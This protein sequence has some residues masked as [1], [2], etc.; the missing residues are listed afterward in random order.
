M[1]TFN[2]P[3]N[4]KQK[5]IEYEMKCIDCKACMKNCPMLDEFCTSPKEL[6]GR[7]GSADTQPLE[8][9]F[10]CSLC[11]YCARVCPKDINFST[12]FHPMREHIIASGSV[13]S[14]PLSKGLSV[15]ANHQK[16]SF[17]KAFSSS[18]P[19]A[20]KKAKTAFIPGCSL[21]SYSPELV[22]SSHK[23]LQ[24][25]I[26][27]VGL[28]IQCCGK[29]TLSVGDLEKFSEYY[30]RLEKMMDKMG[31]DTV[32]TSCQ[33]CYKTIGKYSPH[34]KV[35][36]LWEVMADLGVPEKA[37]GVGRGIDA[38][39]ALHDPCPTRNVASMHEAVREIV[40]QLGLNMVE[41]ESNR[42]LTACCGQGGMIGLTS[43]NLG[44]RQMKKRASEG[45]EADYIITY[46]ESCVESMQSADAK[47][48]H[49]LDIV[50]GNNFEGRDLNQIRPGFAGKWLNRY[51][52]KRLTDKLD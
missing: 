17:S 38:M 5:S 27:D 41:F 47:S 30:S 29:P 48:L 18:F 23:Y 26:G 51:K 45:K 33:N 3:E 20:G 2:T 15:V 12:L 19:K 28:I 39:F 6:L 1:T 25:K 13:S 36:S 37:A 10:S 21:A 50:F 49:L 44:I 16:L 14:K 40:R 24:R 32:I 46:C 31:C 35:I 22:I 9:P 8:L 43:P 52:I 42:S 7:I 11:Q 4:I 34:I